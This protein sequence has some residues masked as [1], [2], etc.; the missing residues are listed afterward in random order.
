MVSVTDESDADGLTVG[1]AAA[2]LGLTV[3]TL[4][5][6]DEIGLARPSSRTAAGYRM[7]TVADVERLRRVVAYRELGLDLGA[8][9]AVL[10][11]PTVDIATELR[12]QRA[13]LA[14]RIDRL[15]S[16][17]DDLERM[18]DAHERGVLLSDA[19]QRTSFGPGWDPAWAAEARQR[20]GATDQWR[21]YAERSAGRS[22][23]EWRSIAR[24]AQEFDTALADAMA[25]GVEPGSAEA[26]RLVDRHREVFS[27]YFP[28]TREMQVL[29]GR[30]YERDPGFA[31]HYERL[32]PGLASWLRLIIDEAARSR[33]IDPDAAVWR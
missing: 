23:E 21:Q 9:R 14:E 20:Y 28:L 24:T 19:E 6:W 4:H 5:H 25:A 27:A 3:R 31:A 11:D 30:R 2:R 26:D 15:A 32:R 10:D 1:R 13:R 29:L 16:L 22:A 7:Y 17:S 8:V 33:G 12:A 18:A